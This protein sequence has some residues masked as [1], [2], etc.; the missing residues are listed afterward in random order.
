MSESQYIEWKESWR[1][2]YL[3]WICGFANADGGILTIGRNDTGKAV[4]VVNAKNLMEVIPNKVRDVLGI[5]VDVNLHVENNKE[6]LEIV[7]EPYPYPISYKGQ[8][9]YRSGST[10]QELK[11]AALDQFLLKKQGR[12][13]DAVP[14]PDIKIDDCSQTALEMFK[15][16]ASKSGRIDDNVLDDTDDSLL[17]NLQLKE[18]GYLKRAAALLFCDQPERFVSGAFIKL[19]FFVTDDDLRYQDEIHGSLFEQVERAIEVLKLKYLKAYIS[20]S[21]LQRIENY[22]FPLPALREA[23]LNAVIH[24]DYSSGI[25]IQISVYD[26]QIVIWNSGQLPEKW[27]IE[28]LLGKHPSH[29]YNPLLANAFFRSGY[30]ESWGRG[31]E[32]I[33]RE[34]REHDIPKPLFDYG[35]S[36]LML[37]FT[38]NPKHLQMA[39]GGGEEETPQ[40]TPQKTPDMI[41]EVLRT[42]ASLSGVEVANQIGKS[43]S[44]VKRAIRKLREEGKL[45]RVGSARGGSWRVL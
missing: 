12:H 10:K 37:T 42:D 36:G 33:Q 20:Y 11:G 45:E 32:K 26:H 34:C 24:K 43:E 22:L 38:A 14:L 9:H 16:K 8:Y 23:L 5:M 29:P 44:A 18:A 17:D 41:L 15:S 4:G 25:P 3:K 35:M 40:K 7:V 28:R 19:G 21:G 13:W 1:D 31:I 2:E 27:T 6:L 30:I 39:L